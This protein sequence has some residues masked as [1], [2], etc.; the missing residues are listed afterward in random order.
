[1]LDHVQVAIVGGGPV[2]CALALALAQ[3]G[4]RVMVLE[5]SAAAAKDARTL[6]LSFGSRLIL[7]RL[8]VWHTLTDVVPI[9]TIHVSQRGGFGRALL[10]AA[11][12]RIPALGY[13]LGY[14][15]L[16]R[17]LQQAA[18]NAGALLVTGAQVKKIDAVSRYGVAHFDK[19]VPSEVE[20]LGA[21]HM[22]RDSTTHTL[23]AR[24]LAICDGVAVGFK[25]AARD[26]HQ[27][28]VVAQV[29]A[30]AP[31]SVLA[32]ERFTPEGPIA[33]LPRLDTY[34][35]IWTCGSK[36]A[37]VIREL[38]D[39]E[40]LA[41]LHHAFGDRLGRFVHAGPRASFPL[42][43]RYAQASHMPRVVLLGNA[44]QALHPVAAQ[45]FNLGLRDAFE[46][47]EEILRSEPDQVGAS[48]MLNAYKGR[49]ANDR[50]AG[51]LLT[52]TLVKLFS[53]NSRVLCAVRGA[54]LTLIDSLPPAKHLFMKHTI[55]GS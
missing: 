12:M 20:E 34:A 43:L 3:A 21:A 18:R 35:L 11:E 1:M 28:A 40:F 38:D 39:P 17:A 10:S 33:L 29:K 45:G 51:I 44:A 52:D 53:N 42:S 37:E 47:S 26:Y 55:Y 31:P 19:P 22:E 30:E 36:A 27:Q 14:G 41:A 13:T 25:T 8:G 2:G 46:L 16:T 6:A 9:E 54:G 15:E 49:R 24:L 7:E 23:T 50:A 48:A 32:F 4:R 5:A